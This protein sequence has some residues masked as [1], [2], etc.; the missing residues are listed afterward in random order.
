M[1]YHQEKQVTNGCMS[2]IKHKQNKQTKILN[3]P[4]QFLAIATYTLEDVK[5][6]ITHKF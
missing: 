4:F 5:Q 1:A 2:C 3:E 6:N